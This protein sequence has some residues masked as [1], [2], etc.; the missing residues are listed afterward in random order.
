M[1]ISQLIESVLSK[2]MC[3]TGIRYDATPFQKLDMDHAGELLRK[4]GY[5][6]RGNEVMYNGMTGQMMHAQIFFGPTYYQRLKHMVSDKYQARATGQVQT[7]VRQPT[8]GRA[9]EGGLRFGEME[10]D[11]IIA[12]GASSFL[13]EKLFLL[14]D[15]YKMPVCNKF[16]LVGHPNKTEC[17]NCKTNGHLVMVNIPYAA[18]LLF[19]ELMAM[20]IAPRV[21]VTDE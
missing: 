17:K 11:A 3:V 5:Q 6:P 19:Q 7:L 21:R 2:L 8:E 13:R 16:G 9:K 18:K 12:H 15:K 20:N 10:R 14:S 4:A 1:T